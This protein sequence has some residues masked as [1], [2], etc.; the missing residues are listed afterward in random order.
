M[1]HTIEEVQAKVLEFRRDYHAGRLTP[2]QIEQLESI[3]GWTWDVDA[4]I[5]EPKTPLAS[6]DRSRPL[7]SCRVA[8]EEIE[9]RGMES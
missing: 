8:G 1:K 7:S 9:T 2:Y 5:P 4:P 3:P 6:H